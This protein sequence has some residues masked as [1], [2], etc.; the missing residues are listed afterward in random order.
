[1]N[2]SHGINRN[3][4]WCPCWAAVVLLSTS[5]HV[6][7][8]PCSCAHSFH[9]FERTCCTAGSRWRRWPISGTKRFARDRRGLRMTRM[10]QSFCEHFQ[11][12]WKQRMDSAGPGLCK[13]ELLFNSQPHTVVISSLTKLLLQKH[14]SWCLWWRN[15]IILVKLDLKGGT[16]DEE[17]FVISFIFLLGEKTDWII[18]CVLTESSTRDLFLLPK[19]TFLC[20]E[21]LEHFFIISPGMCFAHRLK[22]I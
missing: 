22:L 10:R 13:Y 2:T 6:H 12:M 14:L 7:V 5:L 21:T 16:L 15:I 1:M 18:I 20:K 3:K 19:V 9:L 8:V 4:I 17:I 11:F